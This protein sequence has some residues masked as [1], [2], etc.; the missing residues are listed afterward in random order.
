MAGTSASRGERGSRMSEFSDRHRALLTTLCDT[1]IPAIEHQPDPHG[2]YAR[3]ASDLG[4]PDGVA[5]IIQTMPDEQRAGL[6]SLLDALEEQNFTRFSQRSREQVLRNLSLMGPQ[7]A[8]GVQ[9][10][11]NMTLFLFYGLPDELGRNPNWE[12]FGYPGP[13]SAPPQVDKTL[14]IFT[15]EGG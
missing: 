6:L 4:V 9:G 1:V 3:K 15:P 14:P 8:A 10:L 11:I 7:P 2:F 13:V 5:Q 12:M